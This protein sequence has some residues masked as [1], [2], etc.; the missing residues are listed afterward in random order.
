MILQLLLSLKAILPEAVTELNMLDLDRDQLEDPTAFE[1]LLFPCVLVG[2]PGIAWQELNNGNQTGDMSFTTKTIVQLPHNLAFY[3]AANPAG[4]DALQAE[5]ESVLEIE[6][7]VHQAIISNTM[8][9]RTN[10]REYPFNMNGSSLWV[11]EHTYDRPVM[12]Q[13]I[14]KYTPKTTP[15]GTGIQVILDRHGY[16]DQ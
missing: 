13:N 7:S 2:I 12:Y 10:T 9:V 15:T 11:T 5:N 16:D 8:A 1:S 14:P 6:E 3:S 4:F